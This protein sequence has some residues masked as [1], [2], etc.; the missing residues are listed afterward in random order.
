[1]FSGQS[2]FEAAHDH[3]ERAKLHAGGAYRLGRAT[4]LQAN[5]WFKQGMSEKAKLEASCAADVYMKVGAATD[6]EDCRKLLRKIDGLNLDGAGESVH[7]RCHLLRALMCCLKIKRPL[8]NLNNFSG[9]FTHFQVYSP[10][11]HDIVQRGYPSSIYF[12]HVLLKHSDLEGLT[13]RGEKRRSSSRPLSLIIMDSGTLTVCLRKF[14]APGRWLNAH[15]NEFRSMLCN[16]FSTC[17]YIKRV[18]VV[19]YP[20][21]QENL[22]TE[23]K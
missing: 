23:E 16:V 4:E 5:F 2:A 15:R 22:T 6:V 7:K 18:T 11:A 20:Q 17:V 10:I 3:V 14:L 1:M 12:Q 8:E 21:P 9:F 13:D 19:W